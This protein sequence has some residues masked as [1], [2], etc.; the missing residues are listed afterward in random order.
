MQF[1]EHLF[2][3]W[4]IVSFFA[5]D[6]HLQP[7]HPISTAR[8]DD[9]YPTPHVGPTNRNAFH[10]CR[11]QGS[12]VAIVQQQTFVPEYDDKCQIFWG[13][14]GK[15]M[16]RGMQYFGCLCEGWEPTNNSLKPSPPSSLP[17]DAWEALPSVP[18]GR[19]VARVT[20]GCLVEGGGG[21]PLWPEN[22]RDQSVEYTPCR[23]YSGEYFQLTGPP[24]WPQET[25]SNALKCPK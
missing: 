10:V 18:Q 4:P 2:E 14:S 7:A 24:E 1:L 8:H 6:W 19:G 20:W 16:P 12:F 22:R 3:R 5:L 25:L 11:K 9:M 13:I 23:L 21:T 15:A 17:R